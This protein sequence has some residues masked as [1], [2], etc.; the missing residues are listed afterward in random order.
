M[1]AMQYAMRAMQYAAL[2]CAIVTVDYAAWDRM[3]R[4]WT[5]YD[6]PAM[7]R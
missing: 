5:V 7:C 3:T 6:A 1:L 2:T 4:R